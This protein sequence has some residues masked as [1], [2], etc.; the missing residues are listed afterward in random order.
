MEYRERRIKFEVGAG[1]C[2]LVV[3]HLLSIMWFFPSYS[4]PPVCLLQRK[5]RAPGTFDLSHKRLSFAEM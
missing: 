5:H 4:V 3:E 2:S 1:G